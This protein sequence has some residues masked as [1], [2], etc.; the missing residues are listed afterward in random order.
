MSTEEKTESNTSNTEKKERKKPAPDGRGVAAICGGFAGALLVLRCFQMLK[1]TDFETGFFTSPKSATVLPMYII[2]VL[3]VILSVILPRLSSAALRAKFPEKRDI[4]HGAASALLCAGTV[5]ASLAGFMSF[6]ANVSD[7]MMTQLEYLKMN[8][9]Y[10]ELLS[11]VFALLAAVVLAFDAVSAFS[12]KPVAAKLRL[13]HLCPAMWLF[14]VTV[15]YFGI[16]ANYLKEPQFMLLIFAT[17]FFMLFMFE[18]ARFVCGIAAKSAEKL[19][20]SAGII[21]VGLFA[22]LLVPELLAGIFIKDYTGVVNAGFAWWQA[23]A[24]VFVLS[25]LR[26]KL[27]DDEKEEPA[28][29]EA[30]GAESA[31]SN[32]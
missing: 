28:E 24:P 11:P 17:V 26:M 15:K 10:S 23:A 16:T 8:K 32:G 2:F 31:E 30:E 21:S 25:A 29:A 3:F 6:A 27:G 14:T 7:S 22:A 20:V 13:L 9:A 12:G 4:V 5:K 18:Y 1:I 19:Y